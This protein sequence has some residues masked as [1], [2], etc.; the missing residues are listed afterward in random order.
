MRDMVISHVAHR[1][2]GLLTDKPLRFDNTKKHSK[3]TRDESVEP[4]FGCCPPLRNLQN[5]YMWLFQ[6]G[7]GSAYVSFHSHIDKWTQIVGIIVVIMIHRTLILH[8][9][10]HSVIVSPIHS[11]LSPRRRNAHFVDPSDDQ[12]V[13]S[14]HIYMSRNN[15]LQDI[16]WKFDYFEHALP[17]ENKHA[18]LLDAFQICWHITQ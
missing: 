8:S 15:D 7:F 12:S 18:M 4:R 9:H 6:W 16:S 5:I 14:T 17:F 1:W 10:L 11:K 2:V 13:R 3:R